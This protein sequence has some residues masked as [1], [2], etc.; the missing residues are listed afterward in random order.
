MPA[1]NWGQTTAKDGVTPEALSGLAKFLEYGPLGL[2]GLMLVII[3]VAVTVRK[4]TPAMERTLRHLMYIIGGCFAL[5]LAA[6]FFKS[7]AE[8]YLNVIPLNA[9][10]FGG[11]PQP[12]VKANKEPMKMDEAYL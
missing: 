9:E 5:A 6:Q 8:L 7:P 12:T 3:M 11:L 4:L 2:A 1:R 10:A